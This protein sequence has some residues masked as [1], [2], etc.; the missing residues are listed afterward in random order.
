MDVTQIDDDI[1]AVEHMLTLSRECGFIH[2]TTN[3]EQLITGTMLPF[4]ILLMF[5]AD[6]PVRE[7]MSVRYRRLSAMLAD[8]PPATIH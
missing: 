8:P 1:N 7:V 3:I 4:L 2:L 6:G 5:A